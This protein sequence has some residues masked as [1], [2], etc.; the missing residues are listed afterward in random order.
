MI[1]AE[2]AAIRGTLQEK[3]RHLPLSREIPGLLSQ[4]SEVANFLGV[5]ILSFRLRPAVTKDFYKEIP[6]SL[7]VYGD[8][9]RTVGF[10]DS[11]QSLLRLLDV[12]NFRMDMKDVQ[13][14]VRGEDGEMLLENVPRLQTTVEAITFAYI[15][16]SEF[17]PAN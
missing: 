7:T 12:S 10:F 5:E 16:G 8:Y 2:V 4:V 17:S 3:K 11:L 15:E 1:T 14:V 6:I 9:Y 13:E